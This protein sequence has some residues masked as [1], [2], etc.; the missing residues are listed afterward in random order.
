V[1]TFSNQECVTVNTC[2]RNEELTL[3]KALLVLKRVSE[4]HRMR[5]PRL[6][7]LHKILVIPDEARSYRERM[8]LNRPS[9]FKERALQTALVDAL[10]SINVI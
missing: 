8:E 5:V 1:R 9:S 7:E 6:T 2:Q 10:A 4:E 3:Q